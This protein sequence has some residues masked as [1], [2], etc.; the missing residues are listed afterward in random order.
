MKHLWLALAVLG[1]IV[2]WV[3]VFLFFESF[4]WRF[5]LVFVQAFSTLGG[6]FLSLDLLLTGSAVVTWMF[7][8]QRRRPVRHFWV[9]LVGIAAAGLCFAVPCWLY[10]REGQNPSAR[11]VL[12]PASRR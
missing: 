11:R 4:G 3:M 7:V 10:L 6:T 12:S 5:D 8:E 9:P 2:P 1:L